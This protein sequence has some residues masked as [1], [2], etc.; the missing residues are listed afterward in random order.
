MRISKSYTK[1]ETRLFQGKSICFAIETVRA[2]LAQS[3]T[4]VRLCGLWLQ[5]DTVCADIVRHGITSE[6]RIVFEILIA[7][8]NH[9][10]ANCVVYSVKGKWVSGEVEVALLDET[11]CVNVNTQYWYFGCE[12]NTEGRIDVQPK[13]NHSVRHE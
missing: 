8:N 6:R 7:T 5:M 3:M 10:R 1:N 4:N 12:L 11:N 9:V 2:C 13:Q